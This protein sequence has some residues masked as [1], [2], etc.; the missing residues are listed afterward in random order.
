M[1]ENVESHRVREAAAHAAVK[2]RALAGKTS[3]AT[4]SF[5][6]YLLARFQSDGC[7]T[8]AASLSYTSLLAI[9]PMLAIGLA[10]FAAFPGFAG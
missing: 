8:A 3:K 6:R 2:A 7:T 5:L 1:A 4:P 9:V 10:M